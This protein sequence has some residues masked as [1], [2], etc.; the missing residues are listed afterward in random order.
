MFSVDQGRGCAALPRDYSKFGRTT[1]LA[2]Y[3]LL[4][5][6]ISTGGRFSM[7]RLVCLEQAV[8]AGVCGAAIFDRGF[9][10]L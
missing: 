10:C 7:R 8:A 9:F 6:E 3:Q 5:S 4:Y 1:P 2:A